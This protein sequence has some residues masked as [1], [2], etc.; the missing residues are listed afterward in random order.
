M[1]FGLANKLQKY[2]QFGLVIPVVQPCS[3][4]M[5]SA[6]MQHEKHL[7]RTDPCLCGNENSDGGC[8]Y[9][10]VLRLLPFS[11]EEFGGN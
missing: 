1:R 8:D 5:F 3:E 11:L 4:F 2:I 7:H 10:R 6:Q 9:A